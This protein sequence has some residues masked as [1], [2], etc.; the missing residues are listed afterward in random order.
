MRGC[1]VRNQ[2]KALDDVS[3]VPARPAL[4]NAALPS[5][6]YAGWYARAIIESNRFRGRIGQEGI[7]R[8]PEPAPSMTAWIESAMR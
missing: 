8:Q 7:H 3:G 6:A 5:Q 2:C 4:S 1:V